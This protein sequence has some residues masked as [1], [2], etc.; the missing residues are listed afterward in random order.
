MISRTSM[1]SAQL[2]DVTWFSFA[3]GLPVSVSMELTSRRTRQVGLLWSDF[4]VVVV[5]VCSLFRA[6]PPPV[7]TLSWISIQNNSVD[8]PACTEIDIW[9]FFH[10]LEVH[11]STIL[12]FNPLLPEGVGHILLLE[13]C[14]LLLC[15]PKLIKYTH[16]EENCITRR[17]LDHV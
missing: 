4:V 1:S 2:P 7:T 16:F 11:K 10:Y 17:P 3:S 12:I 15:I 9:I 14:S 6:L 8:S 13:L 5:V